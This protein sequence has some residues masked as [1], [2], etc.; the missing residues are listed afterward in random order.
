MKYSVK[1]LLVYLFLL[2]PHGLLATIQDELE[3]IRRQ[4]AQALLHEDATNDTVLSAFVRD[5]KPEHDVSDQMVQELS[6]L[7]PINL[8]KV[9]SYIRQQRADGSWP[10]INYADSRRSGWAP[11][12]HAER[13]LELAKLYQSH[14]TPCYR[15]DSVLQ[16][17]RRAATFWAEANIRCKNWW[18]NEIG[19]PK[20][21]GDAYILMRH[22]MT[23]DDLAR[24]VKILSAARISRTGQNKV[25]LAGVVLVRAI[26]QNDLALARTARRAIL[27]QIVTGQ[28]EGVQPDWSFHQHGPQQQFGNYGLA[29]VSD[30]SFYARI[31]RGTS[32]A[33]DT[34]QVHTLNNLMNQGYRWI[35]WHRRMDVSALDRQLFHNAQV[36]KAYKAAFAAQNLHLRGFPIC[37][38]E[39]VGH[40]HFPCSDYTIHRAPRWMCSLKM[41]SSR[42][43]GTERVNEDNL[44][45]F[46]LADGA[47]YYYVRGDEY[48]NIFPLWD[49]T[50]IPGTTAPP[51]SAR[52]LPQDGREDSRN[53]SYRVGGLT[54]GQAGCSAMELNRLGVHARKMWVFTD[55]Y[56]VCLGG[57]IYDDSATP[58]HTCVDQ[59]IANGPLYVWNDEKKRGGTWKKIERLCMVHETSAVRFYHDHTGYVIV[60]GHAEA[61]SSERTGNWR[62]HMG[63][64]A[65]FPARGRVVQ[66]VLQHDAVSLPHPADSLTYD[67]NLSH[68]A[69]KSKSCEKS[70]AHY[71]YM[72]LPGKT[73]EEVADFNIR[74]SV[75]VFQN[76]EEAQVMAV[77]SM[78]DV[79]WITAYKAGEIS[80]GKQ[81]VKVQAPGIYAYSLKKRSFL[82]S[83]IF[84]GVQ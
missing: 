6:R 25:W 63:S 47:T 52:P 51:A 73:Q 49:W 64:Y 4:Y 58:L 48:D 81:I 66:I 7:Y 29:F 67:T 56:V 40:K 77:G 53:H 79:V 12:T 14:A 41:A 37:G 21:F 15:N 61:N 43:I 50:L 16:A 55:N 76:D 10:D 13:T 32:F 46:Y 26:L 57:G 75:K 45:G 8:E 27:E 36:N 84:R 59:R 44:L 20:T 2:L 35:I 65:D 42:V 31:F 70:A 5:V 78:P 38:N 23:G 62:N 9:W 34:M 33:L 3:T 71:L 28:K 74:K 69:G 18:Y 39:L 80:C 68:R 72:V 24:A 30:M 82:V 1:I 60:D 19:M 54:L 83:E 11:R 22:D 17:F